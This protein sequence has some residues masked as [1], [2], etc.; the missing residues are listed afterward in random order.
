MPQGK[1]F[2]HEVKYAGLTVKEKFAKVAA[3]LDKKADA[4]LITTLDD[5]DW[6][7]NMRGKDIKCNPVFF[8]YAIFLPSFSEGT[9]SLLKL[10]INKEKITDEGVQKHISEN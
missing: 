6:I 8:S 1:V 3:K 9:P 5:I 4:L 7:V 2:V 10:F